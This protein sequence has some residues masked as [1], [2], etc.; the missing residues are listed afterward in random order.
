MDGSSRV[1]HRDGTDRLPRRDDLNF[2]ERRKNGNLVADRGTLKPNHGQAHKS[3]NGNC[4]NGSQVGRDRVR[5][6]EGQRNSAGYYAGYQGQKSASFFE[7]SRGRG[8]WGNQFLDRKSN[9]GVP[10]GSG[11]GWFN[12]S[13]GSGSGHE[14]RTVSQIKRL[15]R[16]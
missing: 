8:N 12:S 16:D 5:K 14:E 13:R 7:E 4:L 9:P 11:S 10:G 1:Y 2:N 3:N 15:L 6:G